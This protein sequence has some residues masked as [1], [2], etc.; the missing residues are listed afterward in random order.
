MDFVVVF[1]TLKSFGIERDRVP[2]SVLYTL[3]GKYARGS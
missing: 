2:L 3:L 1:G